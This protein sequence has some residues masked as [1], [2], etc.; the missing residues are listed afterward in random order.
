MTPEALH[1]I[2]DSWILHEPA[3]ASDLDQLEASLSVRLPAPL[4]ATLQISNGLD[5]RFE[6]LFPH[7]PPKEV[8]YGIPR[9]RQE[10][11]RVRA[12]LSSNTLGA[13]YGFM[14]GELLVVAEDPIGKYLACRCTTGSSTPRFLAID[15][16]TWQVEELNDLDFAD[17][18]YALVS[19]EQELRDGLATDRQPTV[20]ACLARRGAN[21]RTS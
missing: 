9:I 16:R 11:A 21:D 14:L 19:D 3:T 12:Q 18:L 6:L 1:T 20:Q 7:H 10:T 4:R 17:L 8:L 2:F 15:E 13:D 5:V